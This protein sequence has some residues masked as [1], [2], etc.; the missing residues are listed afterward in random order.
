[1]Q[2]HRDK[3]RT[4]LQNDSGQDQVDDAARQHP[5]VPIARACAQARTSSSATPSIT[6]NTENQGKREDAA[7]TAKLSSAAFLP[8]ITDL[9]FFSDKLVYFQSGVDR[10]RQRCI[11]EPGE[12]KAE[13]FG[14]V[15]R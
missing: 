13:E 12:G 10:I 6:K 15:I 9:F 4:G 1:M 8:G 7:L 3:C 5:I 11:A 14:Y 2:C